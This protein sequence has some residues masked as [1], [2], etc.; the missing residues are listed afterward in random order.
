MDWFTVDKEGLAK[1]MARK[2]GK[3]F[4]FFE[5]LQ[6]AWD[7]DAQRIDITTEVIKGRPLVRV[8]VKD[9]DPEGF[10]NLAHAYTLFAESAKK[11]D[12][13]KRGRFNLGE[14]LVLSLCE[15]AEI[16]TTKGM[17]CFDKEGRS[18]SNQSVSRLEKGS[19]FTGLLRMTREEYNEAVRA[20]ATVIPPHDKATFFNNEPVADRK[21]IEGFTAQLKTEIA[22]EEGQ[23]R[24]T[25]RKTLITLHTPNAGETP[26]LYEMGIPIVELTGGE[27]WH[28][29]VHQK[30]PLNTD[31]DNVTPSY[32]RDLR[33]LVLNHMHEYLDD[34][35]KASQAWVRE[36]AADPKVTKEAVEKV[37]KERFG[38]KVV[39]YDPSDPEGSKIAAH[40]GFTVVPGGSLS[41]G[42][43]DNIKR[44]KVI[45]PAGKVTPSKPQA[46]AEH[47]QRLEVLTSGM[48]LFEKFAKAL[49]LMLLGK[50]VELA[51]SF[52][53]TDASFLAKFR[54]DSNRP[55][56]QMN[57]EALGEGWF[58]NGVNEEQL[59]LMLHEFGHFYSSDHLSKAYNDALSSLGA[60]LAFLIQAQPRLLL[61]LE[62]STSL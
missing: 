7:T 15:E 55:A 16:R 36:A 45:Q 19:V 2:G 28:I 57:V 3:A 32:L 47:F 48:K 51:V 26:S 54:T 61:D 53:K 46:T 10:S 52:V 56:L 6:N 13:E 34:A 38:E 11:G 62:W 24:P 4:V 29:N 42:E 14:K 1:L 12:P 9:D 59:D 22:D 30:V 21:F 33:T 23:L 18:S 60:R 31:R 58:E 37:V 20:L 39:A 17:V 41:K 50:Q 27:P 40:E 5:L 49:A 43:W 8:I 44:D 35:D 25:M